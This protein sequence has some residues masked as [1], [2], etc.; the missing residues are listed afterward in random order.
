[1][2]SEPSCC[3][4][5]AAQDP[6]LKATLREFR[7]NAGL[8]LQ[9]INFGS[10]GFVQRPAPGGPLRYFTRCTDNLTQYQKCLANTFY[11]AQAGTRVLTTD[12]AIHECTF[13]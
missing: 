5:A 2:Q 12:L 7:S 4:G 10:S 9:W 13:P 6:D 8:S 1:M 11:M 3:S